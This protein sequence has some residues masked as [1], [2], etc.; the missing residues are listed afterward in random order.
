M[1]S[2]NFCEST[3]KMQYVGSEEQKWRDCVI[4][5]FKQQRRRMDRIEGAIFLIGIMV[6]IVGLSVL[7]L[8]I[9]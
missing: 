5:D 1:E 3:R 7:I 8:E 4:A 9:K 6:M 2:D